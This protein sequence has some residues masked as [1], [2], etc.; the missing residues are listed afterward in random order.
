MI[1]IVYIGATWCS[2]CKIIKPALIEMCKKYGVD[3]KTLDYDTDLESEEQ[4][5][6]TKVPTIKIFNNETKVAEFSNNQI[7]STESWLTANV[8][9]TYNDDF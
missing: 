1:S 3:L 6:I 8:K 4:D 9:L 7:A 5:T 2:T